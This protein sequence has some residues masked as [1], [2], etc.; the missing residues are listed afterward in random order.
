MLQTPNKRKNS[1][2]KGDSFDGGGGENVWYKG[3]GVINDESVVSGNCNY[4]GNPNLQAPPTTVNIDLSIK[5][6]ATKA[7]AS[8]SASEEDSEIILNQKIITTEPEA[9]AQNED[10]KRETAGV[11]VPEDVTMV[12]LYKML[13]TLQLQMAGIPTAVTTLETTTEDLKTRVTTL[14]ANKETT[15]NAIKNL[16]IGMA[17]G[18]S[19]LTKLEQDLAATSMREGE[20]SIP[21]T[22]DKVREI[23]YLCTCLEVVES[24]I[25]QLK[26]IVQKQHVEIIEAQKHR[27]ILNNKVFDTNCGM[28]VNGI[29]AKE[30]EDCKELVGKVLKKVM[31]IEHEVLITRAFCT[32][33][34]TIIFYLTH[35]SLKGSFIKM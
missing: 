12:D 4:K 27:T 17:D 1:S 7:T 35:P 33:G 6:N 2:I 24:K 34:G 15:D 28:M 32:G 30:G 31:K 29:L 9:M 10:N 19:R 26:G 5:E 16:E 22:S 20:G 18:A 3:D 25:E 8:L 11:V 14:E 21:D 23:S 13:A